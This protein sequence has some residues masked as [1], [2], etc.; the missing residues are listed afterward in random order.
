MTRS[1]NTNQRTRTPSGYRITA[2]SLGLAIAAISG[3][4]T[5]ALADTNTYLCQYDQNA[6]MGLIIEYDPK[7]GQFSLVDF[8]GS[9]NLPDGAQVRSFAPEG[10][11]LAFALEYY[12]GRALVKGEDFNFDFNTLASRYRRSLF[13][14]TGTIS[15]NT[16]FPGRC[17]VIDGDSPAPPVI[18]ASPA[19]AAPVA[20][21]SAPPTAAVAELPAG[22]SSYHCQFENRSLV[23]VAFDYDAATGAFDLTDYYGQ[24]E[25]SRSVG[26]GEQFGGANANGAS[27]EFVIESTYGDDL[28]R[29]V[30]YSFDTSTLTALSVTTLLNDD[31]TRSV[32]AGVNGTCTITAVAGLGLDQAVAAAIAIAD[33]SPAAM[34]TANILPPSNTNCVRDNRATDAYL[35]ATWCVSSAGQPKNGATFGPE[36]ML[37]PSAAWCT[38]DSANAWGMHD[39]IDVT[40]EMRDPATRIRGLTMANG[41]SR[42]AAD[43]YDYSRPKQVTVETEGRFWRWNLEDKIGYQAITFDQAVEGPWIRLFI[44]D[45]FPNLDPSGNHNA[46]INEIVFDFSD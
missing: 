43:Y 34:G 26:F 1:G 14:S 19:P 32:E 37:D 5:A 45:V 7:N 28:V 46:C 16:E 25:L 9:P 42:Q 18:V 33:Q 44:N 31:G 27:L 17:T 29:F 21:V 38:D 40:F 22:A 23:G 15:E 30:T 10:A 6:E 4:G 2:A 3:A 20:A 8:N 35:S 39:S 12:Q 36:S 41:V 13:T 24:S 11:A